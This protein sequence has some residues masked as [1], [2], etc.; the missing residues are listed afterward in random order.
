MSQDL[1]PDLV[2]AGTAADSWLRTLL[3]LQ[4]E[5]WDALMRW[6]QMLVDMQQDAWDQWIC[7]W[8]GGVPI[9]A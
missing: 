1:R 3:D 2:D 7:R 8:G 6:Q 4:R 5:Q 9:D